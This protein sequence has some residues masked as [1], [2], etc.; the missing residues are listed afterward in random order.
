MSQ[1]DI[2]RKGGWSIQKL[3]TDVLQVIKQGTAGSSGFLA[4][5]GILTCAF[6]VITHY[7]V[8]SGREGGG[9]GYGGKQT[10]TD[11]QKKKDVETDRQRQR[12]NKE[13]RR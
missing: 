4:E 13:T 2:N 12:E 6:T 10:E 3:F 1:K 7:G 11:T 8:F 5:E 9:R